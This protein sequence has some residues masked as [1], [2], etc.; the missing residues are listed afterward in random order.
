MVSFAIMELPGGRGVVLHLKP[1]VAKIRLFEEECEE[2][3][4]S[5]AINDARRAVKRKKGIGEFGLFTRT[6]KPARIRRAINARAANYLV[7][8]L[9]KEGL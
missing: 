8:R 5:N 3:R 1:P 9:K 4:L 2:T 7:D 6:R